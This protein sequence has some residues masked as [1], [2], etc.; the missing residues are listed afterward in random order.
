MVRARTYRHD[1]RCP[2][3]GSNWGCPKQVL[4]AESRHIAA[5][6]AEGEVLRLHPIVVP[7]RL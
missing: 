2:D 7:V 6:P 3:C 1:V 5:E 4:Q